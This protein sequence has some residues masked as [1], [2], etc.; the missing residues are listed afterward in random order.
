MPYF[1]RI[2]IFVKIFVKVVSYLTG[3][4]EF[5]QHISWAGMQI[6]TSHYLK[7]SLRSSSFIWEYK[8]DGQYVC[9]GYELDTTPTL[10]NL[11]HHDKY[12]ELLSIVAWWWY[13]F[14]C[15]IIL[16]KKNGLKC[17]SDIYTWKHLL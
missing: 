9:I 1:F 5:F 3:S 4:K 2:S 8:N 13:P 14:T 12:Y 6:K 11:V 17:L 10:L 15:D 16:G 7:I